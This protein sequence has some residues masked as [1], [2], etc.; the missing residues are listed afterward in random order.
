LVYK[1]SNNAVRF[2]KLNFENAMQ[3]SV[4]ER[5]AKMIN[6]F[7]K[8]NKSAFA[9]E[10]GISNQSLGEIV[11]ARQSLPSFTAL[12]KIIIAFPQVRI[13]WIVMGKGDMLKAAWEDYMNSGEFQGLYVSPETLDEKF[14]EFNEVDKRLAEQEAIIK[15][16]AEAT[17]KTSTPEVAKRIEN[18]L[19]RIGDT[20]GVV[21]MGR[22]LS[23]PS[24][25]NSIKPVT[26]PIAPQVSE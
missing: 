21:L 17:A 24:D 11:G 7:K 20:E 8:G 15:E 18:A 2:Y 26:P 10:V 19:R 9:K 12:Q 16:I 6:H 23:G 13:E 1:I 14:K 3:T 25:H 4:N 5:I 22:V